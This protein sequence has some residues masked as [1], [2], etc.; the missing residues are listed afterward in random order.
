[1]E[2]YGVI[3]N[4]Q[5]TIQHLEAERSPSNP[6]RKPDPLLV[7]S[8]SADSLLQQT[9]TP[10]YNEIAGDRQSLLTLLDNAYKDIIYM[11]TNL[12]LLV[13]HRQTLL[14]SVLVTL[15]QL[16]RKIRSQLPKKAFKN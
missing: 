15:E 2:M 7:Q 3:E 9:R 1:M 16:G 11:S 14:R 4:L 13:E 8:S 12:D 5:Q 10:S 6:S